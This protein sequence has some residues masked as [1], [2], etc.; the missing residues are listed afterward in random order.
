MWHEEF[1]LYNYEKFS[2]FLKKFVS[3]FVFLTKLKKL[4]LEKLR[5]LRDTMPRHWLLFVFLLSQCYLQ[6]TMPCQWSSSEFLLRVLWIWENVFYSQTFF[7]LHSFL[8][9]FRLP[10]DRQF[11]LNIAQGF[12]VIF[13]KHSPGPAI[14]L[15]HNNPQ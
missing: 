3:A 4:L 10:W 7:T 14:C 11:N 1:F 12:M 6:D 5:D 15:N 9:V 8:L 2:K 13:S